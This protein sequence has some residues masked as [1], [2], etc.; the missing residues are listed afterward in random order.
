MERA[1]LRA[2]RC[3]LVT[4]CLLVTPFILPAWDAADP[5]SYGLLVED[6]PETPFGDRYFSII[7]IL[8]GVENACAKN[9]GRQALGA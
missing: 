7:E 5:R 4:L 1:V 9:Y 8:A 3:H 2:R 6:L